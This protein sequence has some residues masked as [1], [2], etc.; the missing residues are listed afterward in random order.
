MLRYWVNGP[1]HFKVP[2]WLHFQG[3]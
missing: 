3:Q 1:Q 2:C